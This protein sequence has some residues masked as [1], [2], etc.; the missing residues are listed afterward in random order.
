MQAQNIIRALQVRKA[1]LILHQK[2]KKQKKQIKPKK[3]KYRKLS[4]S[5]L[6]IGLRL[7]KKPPIKTTLERVKDL[8]FAVNLTRSQHPIFTA[9]IQNGQI[10]LI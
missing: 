4:L 2:S 10:Q 7:R 3:R 8:W 6:L 5:A 1:A 9:L